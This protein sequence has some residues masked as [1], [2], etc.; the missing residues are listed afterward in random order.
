MWNRSCFSVKNGFEPTTLDTNQGF[1]KCV[2][3]FKGIVTDFRIKLFH[4]ICKPILLVSHKVENRW[5]R[6]FSFSEV[7]FHCFFYRH[8]A[9]TGCNELHI[10]LLIFFTAPFFR[11][12]LVTI[13]L[14]MVSLL[15]VC[16]DI[17]LWMLYNL[18]SNNKIHIE[19]TCMEKY[20]VALLNLT[21]N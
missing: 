19:G 10:V 15:S 12:L 20:E 17:S 2:G 14:G 4:K 1:W 7:H 21:E 11:Y 16:I 3:I 9:F 18:E 5:N 13:S 8:R 6:L